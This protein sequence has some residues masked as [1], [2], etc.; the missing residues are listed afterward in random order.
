VL[1]RALDGQGKSKEARDACDV[2]LGRL[3]VSQNPRLRHAIIVFDAELRARDGDVAASV[4]RIEEA[5]ADAEKLGYLGDVFEARLALARLQPTREAKQSLAKDARAAGFAL[6][7][8]KLGD[9]YQP[10]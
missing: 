5:R 1:G 7:V 6:I 8:R 10:K 3:R 9:T 2:A 4:A